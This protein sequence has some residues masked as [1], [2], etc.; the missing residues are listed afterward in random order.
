MTSGFAPPYKVPTWTLRL[1]P[2]FRALQNGW[3]EET[4]YKHTRLGRF[5]AHTM[6]QHQDL[7]PVEIL[8]LVPFSS[9]KLRQLGTEPIGQDDNPQTRP[10][11]FGLAA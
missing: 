7:R 2:G 9:R 3:Q 8:R 11:L 6:D 10:F 4:G 1:A 5:Y